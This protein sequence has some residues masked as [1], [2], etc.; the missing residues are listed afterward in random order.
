M[1]NVYI[2]QNK[3]DKALEYFERSLSLS[4]QL[5]S[6]SAVPKNRR[7]FTYV[8]NRIGDVYISQNQFDKASEYFERSLSLSEQLLSESKT[9]QNC[10]ELA[11]TIAKI[12]DVYRNNQPDKALKYYE[13]SHS[14]LK[15]LLEE[16]PIPQAV[17]DMQ[18]ISDRLEAMLRELDSSITNWF[19]GYLRAYLS[20]S[21]FAEF[22]NFQNKYCG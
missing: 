8:L 14:F 17:K 13:R 15:Q 22:K 3:L 10:R 18:L 9:P 7:R 1:N 2:S 19:K 20:E 12:G 16:S 6:E 4:E 11:I 5:I 21:E